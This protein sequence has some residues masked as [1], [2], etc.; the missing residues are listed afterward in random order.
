MTHNPHARLFAQAQER[1]AA[2]RQLF[3][4]NEGSIFPA[5]AGHQNFSRQMALRADAVALFRR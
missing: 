1:D 2:I 3:S 4:W 5:C